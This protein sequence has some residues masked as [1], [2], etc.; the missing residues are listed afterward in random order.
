MVA[1]KHIAQA[2]SRAFLSLN[3][4]YQETLRLEERLVGG[5]AN[6]WGGV[7]LA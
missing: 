2:V 4:R 1:R 3:E 6:G 5:I 7:G